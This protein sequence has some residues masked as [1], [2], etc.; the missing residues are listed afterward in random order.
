MVASVWAEE[1]GLRLMKDYSILKVT[2]RIKRGQKSKPKN[3]LDKINKLNQK[4]PM[5]NFSAMK[6]FNN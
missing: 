3:S 4:N 5:P 2:K 1:V 6:V